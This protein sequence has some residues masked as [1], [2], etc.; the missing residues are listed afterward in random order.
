MMMKAAAAAV[1]ARGQDHGEK[2]ILGKEGEEV[3]F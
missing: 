3:K 2:L 1:A